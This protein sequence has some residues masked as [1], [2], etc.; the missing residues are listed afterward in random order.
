MYN[1]IDKNNCV[2]LINKSHSRV[3]VA[4]IA[5]KESKFDFWLFASELHISGN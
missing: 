5:R 3:V 4:I 2:V 1:S